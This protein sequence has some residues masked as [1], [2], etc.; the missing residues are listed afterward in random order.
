MRAAQA[1][2][3]ASTP[4]AGS[5]PGATVATPVSPTPSAVL[6]RGAVDCSAELGPATYCYT[7]AECW[8]GIISIADVAVGGHAAPCSER[9]VYQTFAPATLDGE[10]LKQSQLEKMS[11]R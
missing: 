5:T 10:H 7:A 4:I 11:R 9:H 6:P 1:A 3:P 2:S 8:A